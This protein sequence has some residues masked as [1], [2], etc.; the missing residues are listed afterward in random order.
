[1][2]A[3]SLAAILGM[4]GV[5]YACRAGGLWLA[6]RFRPTPFVQ[7]WLAQLPGAVFAALVAPMVVAAGPAGWLA[8]GAGFATM[9]WTGQFL[10]A[11]A[12]GLV[13]YVLLARLVGA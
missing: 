5:T 13:V 9:R 11:F 3:A 6:R 2:D 12:A 10:V 7:A 1:M 8:A 4:A